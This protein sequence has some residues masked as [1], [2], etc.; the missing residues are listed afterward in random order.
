[1]ASH[2]AV[3]DGVPERQ[4]RSS[5]VNMSTHRMPVLHTRV[6]F[7]RP[8]RPMLP[9]RRLVVPSPQS[10]TK[11][12]QK[13]SQVTRH[14]SAVVRESTSPCPMR[15]AQLSASSA[16]P[17][18]TRKSGFASA[19]ALRAPATSAPAAVSAA[20]SA[21]A[22]PRLSEPAPA[23]FIGGKDRPAV[24]SS[25]GIPPRAPVSGIYCRLYDDTRRYCHRYSRQVVRR[26]Q[27]CRQYRRPRH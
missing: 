8:A 4:H 3:S 9:R 7:E 26:E 6:V 24:P 5:C 10:V 22:A 20:R 11:P 17:H 2:D 1:M 19:T 15:R 14:T 16:R 27:P 25:V 18:R 12:S 23:V 13:S 21:A